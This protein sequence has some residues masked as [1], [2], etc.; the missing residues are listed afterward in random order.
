MQTHLP[1]RPVNCV[2]FCSTY[3]YGFP[4]DCVQAAEEQQIKAAAE[5]ATATA[6]IPE[7]TP[8]DTG[9]ADVSIAS[10][11]AP[12]AAPAAAAAAAASAAAAAPTESPEQQAV[13]AATKVMAGSFSERSQQHRTSS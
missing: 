9:A 12:V 6:A 3:I 2:S 10:V 11:V 13:A 1:Y 8:N 7:P 4:A 5:L